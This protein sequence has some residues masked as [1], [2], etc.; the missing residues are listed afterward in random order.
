MKNVD[1][2]FVNDLFFRYLQDIKLRKMHGEFGIATPCV[3][4][5]KQIKLSEIDNMV[6]IC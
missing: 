6:N 2:D 3:T 1:F 5:R 4:L